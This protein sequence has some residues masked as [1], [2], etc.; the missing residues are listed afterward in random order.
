M[1]LGYVVAVAVA[2][3]AVRVAAVGGMKQVGEYP[4]ELR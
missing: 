3:V 4:V 1:A 2:V